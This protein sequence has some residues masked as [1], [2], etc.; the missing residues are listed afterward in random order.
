MA[1]NKM[2]ALKLNPNK[3]S[4]W[5]KIGVTGKWEG[6]NA[7]MF[8]LEERDYEQMIFNAQQRALDIVVDYEH[9]TI[10]NPDKAPAAGWITLENLKVESGNLYCK[11]LWTPTA[12]KHIDAGEYKYL[13]PVFVADSYDQVTAKNIGWTLHSVAL[14]NKPFL[15]ELDAITNKQP[16]HKEKNMPKSLQEQLDTQI[17]HN[18][19][20][21]QEVVDL[22]AKVTEQ[23]TIIAASHKVATDAIIEAAVTDGKLDEGQKTWAQ[24]YAL[25]D[26]QGFEDYMSTLKAKSPMSSGEMFANSENNNSA[27][28][29]AINMT[30]V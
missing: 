26:K 5:L 11:I 17:N 22:K 15:S 24:N 21:T 12:K 18:T 3:A 4:G 13:S 14:T 1:K 19:K 25:S 28:T 6:H 10:Y 8:E 2:H 30:Q 23:E 29:A 27:A 20:L 16:Q 7:G 9:A